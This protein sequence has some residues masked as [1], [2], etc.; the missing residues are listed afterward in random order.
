M[1]GLFLCFRAGKIS[2]DSPVRLMP[3]QAHESAL[4]RGKGYVRLLDRDFLHAREF[5]MSATSSDRAA[6]AVEQIEALFAPLREWPVLALAV[7]GGGDSLALMHLAV[8]WAT[9]LRAAGAS[10]PRLQVLTVDHGLRADS[11]ATAAD[12]CRRAAALGLPCEV[13]RWRG[14][15][16]RTGVEEAA[17]EAR[18][19][20]LAE[21]C[22]AHDAAL[23][24]AHTLEDQ[25]ETFLMRLA[26]GSGLDGLC[27]MSVRARV[28]GACPPVPLL[29]P[30]LSVSRASLR[31]LLKARGERW[32]E[33]PANRDLRFERVR[34]RAL[35]PLLERNG[36]SPRA[37]LSSTRRLQRARAALEREAAAFLRVHARVH[38]L[39]FATLKRLAFETC[40]PEIR[41]RILAVLMGWLGGN[42]DRLRDMAGLE[43]LLGWLESGQGRARVLAG[44]QLVRR[45][46][47]ILMGREPGRPGP[48][49]ELAPGDLA[50]GIWD[51]RFRIEA[52]GLRAPVRV[53][54]LAEAEML[55]ASSATAPEVPGRPKAVPAFVWRAQPAVVCATGCAGGPAFLA[56][57]PALEWRC[58]RAPFDAVSA[59]LLPP[60]T[61]MEWPDLRSGKSP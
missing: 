44:A 9:R 20:L 41:L 37:I 24:T 8:E 56:A 59:T 1:A 29:R 19:G 4:W 55:G 15:K 22:R 31:A 40:E 61:E 28:P 21:W 52:T 23:V 49:L 51:R 16:P 6:I 53:M 36:I 58:A 43:R 11:A 30:L 26:R 27:A 25:A 39:G 7:S 54:M 35:L 5:G 57:L 18:Y 38:A 13:L 34:L 14:E 60:C 50:E 32:H 17:R 46:R 47:E 12:V 2:W 3:G 48:V 45:K 33:D 42:G 10:V